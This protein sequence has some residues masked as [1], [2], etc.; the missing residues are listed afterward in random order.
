MHRSLS[1]PRSDKAVLHLT[2]IDYFP[3]R[4]ALSLSR[5][6]ERS[7]AHEVE[8]NI[9]EYANTY[10]KRRNLPGIQKQLRLALSPAM[11]NNRGLN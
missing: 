11:S 7:E 3:F 5:F 9:I 4:F 1:L 2:S 10:K 6:Q 8:D